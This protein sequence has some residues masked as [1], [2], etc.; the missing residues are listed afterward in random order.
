[1][2]LD[3]RFKRATAEMT[4]TEAELTVGESLRQAFGHR[5]YLLLTSGFFVCG[6][7][8]GFVTAH[9]PAYVGDIGIEPRYAVIAFALIGFFNIIGALASGVIGDSSRAYMPY[10]VRAEIQRSLMNNCLYTDFGL[11]TRYL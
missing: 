2:E 10:N 11:R 9:F 3:E 5:G 4:Q 8:L 1:M 7:Q 6:F